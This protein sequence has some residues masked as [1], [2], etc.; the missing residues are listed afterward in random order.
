MVSSFFPSLAPCPSCHTHCLT[1]AHCCCRNS[2]CWKRWHASP[3]SPAS[4]SC[5]C[6]NHWAFGGQAPSCARSTSLKSGMSCTI[7][8]CALLP[9][10]GVKGF[11]RQ[12]PPGMSLTSL[13]FSYDQF[14]NARVSN[15]EKKKICNSTRSGH[16]HASASHGSSII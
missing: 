10:A 16:M 4:P 2:G 13:N 11:H 15:Q 3:T 1:L 7:Y 5:T 14:L 12:V 9:L 6:M 8:R